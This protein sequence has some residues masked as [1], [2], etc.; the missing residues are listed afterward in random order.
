LVASG[1][2]LLRTNLSAADEAKLR[3]AFG[4]DEEAAA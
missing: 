3:A 4:A 1:A 2:T